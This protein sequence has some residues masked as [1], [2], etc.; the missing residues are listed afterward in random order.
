MDNA[1]IAGAAVTPEVKSVS[2]FI[3]RSGILQSGSELEGIRIRGITAGQKFPPEIAFSGNPIRFDDTA[4]SQQIILSLR[5]AARL[6]VAPGDAVKLY[7]I[8]G[9]TPR[10]RK[11][12]I[13]GTYHTGMDE[14]DR[15]YAL[16]DIRLLQ[17]LGGWTPGQ[18]SGYA[19]H[20]A[21][22]A[23][24]DTVADKL[25]G[26]LITPPLSARSIREVYAGVFDWLATLDNNGRL[27][28]IIVSIVA[29]INLASAML[30]LMVDRAVMIGMLKALGMS[31]G[32]LWAVFGYV[33]GLIAGLGI[34]IGNIAGIGLCLLQ[35]YTAFVKL[36]EESYNTP[37]APVRIEWSQVLTLDAGALAVCVLCTALPLLYLRRI[38][39][40]RVLQFG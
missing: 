7:F 16:C 6:N 3:L 4:Y 18:I 36:P 32:A 38:Q 28:L 13:A 15:Q 11:L 17:R 30:I 22:D 35:Q 24:A 31:P 27:L 23:N 29:I 33:A 1:L 39:P 20:I 12:T 40:A 21:P 5:T 8:T 25:Y 9:G 19:V 26:R 14:V 10:I 34:L 2:P 37:F